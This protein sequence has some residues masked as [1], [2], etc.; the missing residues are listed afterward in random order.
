MKTGNPV[1]TLGLP[2]ESGHVLSIAYHPQGQIFASGSDDRLVRLWDD[3]SKTVLRELS[4]HRAFSWCMTFHPQGELLAS[5]AHDGTVKLWEVSSGICVATFELSSVPMSVSFSPD[6]RLLAAGCDRFIYI[7]DISTRKC[8][9]QLE[10]HSNVVSS[11]VFHPKDSSSLI[12]ASYDETI[13]FWNIATGE[14]LRILRPDR[15]YEGMNIQRVTGLS[16]GQKAVLKQLG[17]VEWT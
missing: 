16:A 10:G 2:E 7:W 9:K 5:G 17:A 8:L 13:R 14:C 6:G 1:H 15:I 12:S 11:L 4:G 3:A